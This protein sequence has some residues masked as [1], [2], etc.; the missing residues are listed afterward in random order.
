MLSHW[1]QRLSWMPETFHFVPQCLFLHINTDG[2][3]VQKP[4]WVFL[5]HLSDKPSR[6][7]PMYRHNPVF[8]P[9]SFSAPIRWSPS[10]SCVSVTDQ[11]RSTWITFTTSSPPTLTM[12]Q[13]RI[14]VYLAHACVFKTANGDAS[15]NYRTK[16]RQVA[17]GIQNEIERRVGGGREIILFRMGCT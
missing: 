16:E 10:F 1:P 17:C 12:N 8:S 9:S 7:T 14:S 13:A 5:E 2:S 6:F 11:T 3:A 4:D 15:S